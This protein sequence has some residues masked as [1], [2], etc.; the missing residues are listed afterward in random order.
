MSVTTDRTL[1]DAIAGWVVDC[2]YDSLPDE[3]KAESRKCLINSVG[4]AIGSYELDDVQRAIA[5]GREEG[6]GGAATG[7]VTGDRLA[8]ATASF[9]NGV[10]YNTLGQEETHLLSGT[11][12]AETVVPAL[13]A[14]GE[15][16]GSSGKEVLEAL[17]VGVD[18]AIAVARMELT[19]SVKYDQCEA[20]AVYGTVGAAAGVAK[21][22]GLDRAGIAEAINLAANFAAGLSECLIVGTGEYH[23][24]VGLAPMHAYMAARLAGQGATAA[25]T[26]LEGRSGFYHLFG[27]A[28]REAL[29]GHDV[30]GDV[31]GRLESS[32]SMP[33]MIYKPYPVN[34]FNQVFVDGARGLREENG[35]EADAIRRIRIDIGTLASNSG[36]LIEPPFGRRES[37]LGSTRFCVAAML[38]RGRLDVGTTQDF[39]APGVMELID[40]TEVVTDDGLTTTKIEVET[41]A[42]TFRFDGETEG[43]DY[44][45]PQEEIEGIFRGAAGA[46]LPE[47]QVEELLDRLV[48]VDSVDDVST[49][50]PLT[51][52]EEG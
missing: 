10:M 14:L 20:P 24:I 42:G 25:P 7:L 15:V 43:R 13:L 29:A 41:D 17:V 21:L 48:E 47:A 1:S 4:T 50:I 30:I 11:H 52:A 23:F 19:P 6:L 28:D 34:Y 3:M 12:P 31:V 16:R 46:V 33:E 35:I 26:A 5:Y 40:K 2:E 9:V 51:V 8:P 37:V 27:D 32:W 18:V 39:T 22:A 36:A 44:R 49:L 38:A 45:L